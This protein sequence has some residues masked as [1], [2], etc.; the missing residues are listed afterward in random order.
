MEGNKTRQIEDISEKIT[1]KVRLLEYGNHC[2]KLAEDEDDYEYYY[3]RNCEL[4]NEIK[5]LEKQRENLK[6]LQP[7][8]STHPAKNTQTAKPGHFS[9]SLDLLSEQLQKLQ[10]ALSKMSQKLELIQPAKGESLSAKSPVSMTCNKEITVDISKNTNV[11]LNN[12]VNH[13]VIEVSEPT[14]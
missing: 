14:N 8:K 7:V 13:T 1:E 6:Y 12:D 4:K 3:K 2:L 5:S 10:T 11:I 9:A